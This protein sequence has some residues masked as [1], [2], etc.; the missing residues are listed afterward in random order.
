MALPLEQMVKCLGVS[1]SWDRA[2]WRMTVEDSKLSL[3]ESGDTYYS[4]SDVLWLSRLIFAMAAEESLDAQIGVGSVCV[5]RLHNEA[6]ARPANIYEVVT[7]K[8]QFTVATNGMI[9]ATPTES[10]VVAAKLALEGCDL[11]HGATFVNAGD[12]GAGYECVAQMGQLRFF[13]A[14]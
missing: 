9:Y 7:A 13:T 11:T 3:L 6:F 5:N 14:A 8:N 2:K 12:M 4:E 10:C 1:V